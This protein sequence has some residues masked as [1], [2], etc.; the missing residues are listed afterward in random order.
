MTR[1][2]SEIGHSSKTTNVGR[3][4]IVAAGKFLVNFED[5]DLWRLCT[6][7]GIIILVANLFC[8]IELHPFSR[9]IMVAMIRI[10]NATVRAPTPV[11]PTSS[12]VVHAVGTSSKD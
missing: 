3:A 9:K 1:K 6:I 11:E 10:K 4:H 2:H 7:R 5:F 8:S 12:M